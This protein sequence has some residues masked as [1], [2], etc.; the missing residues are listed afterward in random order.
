M[1]IIDEEERI[2]EVCISN[3]YNIPKFSKQEKECIEL[4]K[5]LKA[6][7]KTDD[8]RVKYLIFAVTDDLNEQ[9]K[10]F[11]INPE[12]GEGKAKCR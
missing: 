9:V 10:D 7:A 4:Y 2:K 3:G 6:A 11:N 5:K 12:N 8:S 1:D